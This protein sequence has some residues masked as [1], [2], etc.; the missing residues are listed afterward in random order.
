MQDSKDRLFHRLVVELTGGVG[1][2]SKKRGMP[3]C[4]ECAEILA[5]GLLV[6]AKKPTHRAAAQTTAVRKNN[7]GPVAVRQS[8][9][10]EAVKQRCDLGEI[11]EF[12]AQRVEVDILLEDGT[13]PLERSLTRLLPLV[14]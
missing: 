12:L 8:A 6:D 9:V 1:R 5:V 7:H 2:T 14:G 13:H 3:A 4:L 11:S 10:V